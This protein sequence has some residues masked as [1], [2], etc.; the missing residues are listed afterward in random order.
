MQRTAYNQTRNEQLVRDLNCQIL[1]EY[2]YLEDILEFGNTH[3]WDKLKAVLRC[4]GGHAL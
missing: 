3:V 4:P 2:I 1:L